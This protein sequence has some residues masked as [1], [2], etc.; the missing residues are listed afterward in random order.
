V[1]YSSQDHFETG[2]RDLDHPILAGAE[3]T[4]NHDNKHKYQL[5]NWQ[6]LCQTKEHGGMG[7]PN[8]RDINVLVG[9]LDPKIS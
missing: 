2:T 5:S 9:I 7:I 6:S 1:L 3:N 4:D 8:L